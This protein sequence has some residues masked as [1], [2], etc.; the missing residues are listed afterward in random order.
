M[1]GPAAPPRIWHALR[2]DALVP[3]RTVRCRGP[4]LGSARI[5]IPDSVCGSA[6]AGLGIAGLRCLARGV[7]PS[8]KEVNWLSPRPFGV[9]TTREVLLAAKVLRPVLKAAFGRMAADGKRYFA[10]EA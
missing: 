4:R 8:V 10:N 7:G 3:A 1:A 6:R 9:D 2:H 5:P